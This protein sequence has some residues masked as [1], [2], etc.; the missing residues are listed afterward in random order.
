[1]SKRLAVAVAL[2]ATLAVVPA[3]YAQ[4]TTGTL[5]GTVKDDT[6]GV[7]QSV[8]V[9]LE[10]E[11]IVG[12]MTTTTSDEGFYRFAALPPGTYEVDFS[13]PGFAKLHRRGVRVSVGATEE[14]SVVLKVSRLQEEMTVVG[15]ASVVDTT[16][17]EVNTNYDKDWVRNAPI[18]RY[19][20]FDLI[21][22]APGV[23]QSTAGG[24]SNASSSSFGSSTDENSYQLDGTDFTAPL[25]GEAWPYPNTDAIEEIEILSLGA[26]AEYGSL[27]G[28][29][30][31]VVTRQGSNEFHG[32]ANLY[33]QTQDLTGR[34][35][36][37]EEDG[38][39]PFNRDRFNDLTFQ[40]G[41]PI[42]KDRL[43]FFGSYQYQRDYRS[44]PGVEPQFPVKEKADRI[45]FKLNWQIN[46]KN[47]LMFTYHDDYYDLPFQQ[48]AFTSPS[49]IQ[50]EYGNNPSPGVTFTSVLS[51][52]TYFEARYS[53]FYGNDHAKPL[54]ECSTPS[55]ECGPRV[56]PR[57]YDLDTGAIT[58][59]IYYWYEGEVW[60]SAVS[61][62]VSHFADD[63]LG[64][65]HDFKF[66]VQYN[67]GGSDYLTGPNDYIYTYTYSDA[68]GYSYP[69]GYG[70]SIN[71]YHYGGN[72]RSIGVYVDDTFRVNDRLTINLGVR[73]DN[74]RASIPSFPIVDAD[75][76]PTGETSAA[77]DELYS[78]NTFSPRIGFNFKLTKD[79]KT[80]L[81]AHY[82]RYYRGIVTGEFSAVGPSIPPLFLGNYN[83]DSGQLEDLELVQDNTNL[84]VDPGYKN[85]YTDQ[86]IASLERE[87]ARNMALSFHYVYKRGRNY[88]AWTDIRGVY[89]DETLE[90]PDT[91]AG[92]P[93]KVL[94]NDPAE[95]LF[96]LTNP[97]EMRTTINA[98]T[99]QFTKR[100]ADHWQ[101]VTSLVYSE[102]EGRL[103]SSKSDLESSPRGSVRNDFGQN[104]NDFVNTDG[105]LTLDRPWV[106]KTQLVVELPKGFLVSANYINQSGRPWARTI[107]TDLGVPTLLLAE[108]IDGSRRVPRWNILDTRLQWELGLSQRVRLALFA[109]LLNA[110]NNDANESVASRETG[111]DGFGQPTI[112]LDPRRLMLGAKIRF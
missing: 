105:L 86:F 6:G 99:V 55:F 47:K 88:G 10:G 59:G 16:S 67:S 31:N 52:K 79:A 18:R 8:T 21:N 41:G 96:R 28:A 19:T 72:M 3:T 60:K 53:G 12:S 83:F 85:P 29:V 26:P 80:T 69:V 13:M 95:R 23:T 75:G 5:V 106:F 22:A 98:F 42:I 24:F 46:S 77:I 104:P 14:V 111:S 58:G 73:Y 56:N 36:T 2:L 34:N 49:S 64:G 82:G 62:K 54:N 44:Q 92:I 37:D 15:E 102:A 11:M 112:F 87:V 94:V 9:T 100:M 51:D 30:F 48:T 84:Q 107:R 25:T 90:D 50:V 43:W 89:E 63:F 65:S 7:L 76:N 101:L 109:D 103:A 71:P 1:L 4:R 93:V 97:T 81:R 57:F 108:K 20:F 61:A 40:L 110:F 66:G 70:Y 27:Q 35:T 17:N 45:F 91:G 33:F 74:Q 38:G 78:W 68:Y 32:D 39:L